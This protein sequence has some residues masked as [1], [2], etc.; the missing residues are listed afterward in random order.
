MVGGASMIPKQDR[1]YPRKPSDLEQK[2]DL[3]SSGRDT[4]NS[5]RISQLEQSLAL[6]TNEAE[7]KFQNMEKSFTDYKKETDEKLEGLE[8]TL[9]VATETTLGGVMI[10]DGVE[11]DENGKISVS[12]PQSGWVHHEDAT[13]ETGVI[14]L[15]QFNELHVTIGIPD[16][17]YT[18]HLLADDLTDE[19]ELFRNGYCISPT[20]YGDV[21]ISVSKTQIDAWTVRKE[22]VVQTEATVKVYC[23]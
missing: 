18:F 20:V 13:G 7:V 3:G 9:P 16:Y 1:V 23:R 17:M 15:P 4:G 22:G 10:G 19:A 6:H 14:E 21:Y 2:Y 12:V 5:V 8:Y 11:I